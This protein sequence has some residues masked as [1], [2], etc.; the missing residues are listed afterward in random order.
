MNPIRG[1]AALR[2]GGLAGRLGLGVIDQVLS[3]TSNFVC[4]LVAARYLDREAFG[5]FAF[6][7]VAY[8][9]NL[10]IVR[11]LCSEA[12]LVRPGEDDDERRRRGALAAGSACW[13]GVLLGLAYVLLGLVLSDEV[14][15]ALIALGVLTPGLMVQDTMRYVSFGQARPR[16]ALVNDGFWLV[17]Q[18]LVL[19][20]LVQLDRFGPAMLVA[21]WGTAG[22]L[23]GGLQMWID[24]T[25]PAVRRGFAWIRTNR[26]LS[27]RYLLDM[28]SGQ[29]SSL[30]ASY[31]LALVA[32]MAAVGSIR[33]AQTLFGP[34]NI[35]LLGS[36]I[37]LVPEGRRIAQQ[38]PR[39]L[40]VVCAGAATVFAGVAALSTLIF[41]GLPEELGTR[42]LGSTWEGA[43]SVMVPVGLAGMAGGI[44]AGA[45]IGLRSLSAAEALLR[46]RLLA[47]PVA[48]CLPVAGAIL[49][50][51]TGLAWGIV[52]SVSWNVIWFWR[53]FLRSLARVVPDS[54]VLAG[55]DTTGD[56]VEPEPRPEVPE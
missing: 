39:K 25:I 45:L 55:V 31:V 34:V 8:T 33:G 54:A 35:I 14:G 1:R 40:V 26:D 42:V 52:A 19:V 50:D 17:A 44:L 47:M 37:V 36:N 12:I 20:A 48:I 6:A 56:A 7:I 29:G 15:G 51:E 21:G 11:A 28:V 10:L 13:V 22:V 18:L 5:A 30:L 24:S 43:R 49:A 9:M 4:T 41:V 46:T 38:S 2:R 16:S 27:V 32:G 53:T 3:S 23:A